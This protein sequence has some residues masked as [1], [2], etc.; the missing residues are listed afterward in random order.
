LEYLRKAFLACSQEHLGEAEDAAEEWTMA[1]AASRGRPDA[2]E[3][4]VKFALQAKWNNRAEDLM[5][6]LAALPQSPR[7]VLLTLWERAYKLGETAKL[8]RLSSSMAMQ[9]PKGVGSRNNYAFLSLLIR[10]EEGQPHRVA[11]S[12]HREQ[13]EN[14]LIASTYGLSLYQ[15]GKV[16][17][18]VAVMSALQP[19][20]L[21]QPQVAL[22]YA[23]FLFAAGQPE[24]AEGYLQ[25]SANWPMLPEEKALLDRAR[26]SHSK[27]EAPRSPAPAPAS[28][29]HGR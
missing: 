2:Q 26:L 1:V 22:Y 8:Q 9:D 19:G 23:I 28:P 17:A 14:A 3:R 25:L 12:L 27:E 5:W 6:T 10:T 11:E 20:D 24:Q 4:L 13:P 21:R 16:E 15:Q 18:A 7:W 29:D